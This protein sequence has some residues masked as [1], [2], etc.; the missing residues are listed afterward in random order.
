MTPALRSA[1]MA[2][3]ARQR[4]SRGG[5][6]EIAHA[7][8]SI[9]A[10]RST[11]FVRYFRLVKCAPHMSRKFLERKDVLEGMRFASAKAIA[12]AYRPS[13]SIAHVALALG[14]EEEEDGDETD[15][16]EDADPGA[17]LQVE[18]CTAWLEAHGG[19]LDEGGNFATKEC[20][21]LLF[22]PKDDGAVAHGDA[23]L[24]CEDFLKAHVA[25]G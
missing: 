21:G 6:G 5:G 19:R 7:M 3:V 18:L 13:V 25:R 16:E 12:A 14:F 1:Y 17:R 20:S 11:D 24:S 2:A 15:A 23:N 22:V 9:R 10:L 8:E 4:V